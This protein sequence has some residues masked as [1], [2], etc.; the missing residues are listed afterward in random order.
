MREVSMELR[1]EREEVTQKGDA[2][3]ARRAWRDWVPGFCERPFEEE[4]GDK[5]RESEE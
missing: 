4:K 1:V 5:R 3:W 2:T